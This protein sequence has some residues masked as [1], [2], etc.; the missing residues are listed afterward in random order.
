MQEKK[1][2]KILKIELNKKEKLF[3]QLDNKLIIYNKKLQKKEWYCY[4]TNS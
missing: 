2:N 4:N 1:L 3:I